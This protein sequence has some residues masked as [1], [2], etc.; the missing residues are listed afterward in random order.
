MMMVVR[1]GANN[2]FQE[3][4]HLFRGPTM[5]ILLNLSEWLDKYYETAVRTTDLRTDIR[6]RDIANKKQVC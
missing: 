3:N 1:L 2:T 5:V 4:I 6:T